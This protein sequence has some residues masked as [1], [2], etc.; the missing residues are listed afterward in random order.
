MYVD[1][2]YST[3]G[4]IVIKTNRKTYIKMYMIM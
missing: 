4:Q 2:C 3:D 1:I